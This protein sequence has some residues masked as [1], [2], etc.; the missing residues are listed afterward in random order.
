MLNLLR[1]PTKPLA[2]IFQ[3]LI[4]G[5]RIQ[6]G[7]QNRHG[8]LL[9]AHDGVLAVVDAAHDEHVAVHGLAPELGAVAAP[10]APLAAVVLAGM[11]GLEGLEEVE[12]DRDHVLL[13]VQQCFL[14]RLAQ[15]LARP[16]PP[17]DHA[18]AVAHEERELASEFPAQRCDLTMLLSVLR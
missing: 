5:N 14:P 2:H 10:H 13:R 16:R 6:V 11:V 3:S 12:R 15:V 7:E 8:V 9:L 4:L 1:F 17:A 18:F